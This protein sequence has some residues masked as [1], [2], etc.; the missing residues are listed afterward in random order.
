MKSLKGRPIVSGQERGLALV[1]QQPI[2]FLGGVDPHSGKVIERDHDLKGRSLKGRVLCFPHGHGSTVGSYVLY[3]LAKN[4]VG[5]KAIL[6]EK[7]DPVVVV[8][9]I[10]AEIPMMDRVD[11][12]QI[13]TDDEVE[14]DC[15]EGTAKVR[16]I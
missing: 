14:V 3:S 1:S 5:P 11:I 8:G 2:S 6:N 16:K 4:G 7:A 9:A 10:I 15:D 13:E 12:G